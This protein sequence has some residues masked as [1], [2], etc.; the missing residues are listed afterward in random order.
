MGLWT[1]RTA[2]TRFHMKAVTWRSRYGEGV[3][4]LGTEG[5]EFWPKGW[6]VR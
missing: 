2:Y 1:R 6:H 3:R 5:V 4:S